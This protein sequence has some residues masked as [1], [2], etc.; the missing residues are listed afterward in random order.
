MQLTSPV[1]VADKT[2][3]HA[4]SPIARLMLAGRLENHAADACGR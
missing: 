3:S 2:G 1:V 4:E